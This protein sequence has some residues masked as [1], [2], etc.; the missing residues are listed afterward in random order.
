MR[1][2]RAVQTNQHSLNIGVAE[3]HA[4][5]DQPAALVDSD[6]DASTRVEIWELD[7]VVAVEELSVR[8]DGGTGFRV[9]SRHRR[10]KA[11]EAR[12]CWHGM[13]THGD[14]T[15]QVRRRQVGAE[16]ECPL[17]RYSV[18]LYA[19]RRSSDYVETC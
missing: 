17:P 10:A 12:F 13:E 19:P 16:A 4:V 9:V 5:I 18:A 1:L 3:R 6:E 11:G 15:R 2:E 7:H 8:P 14:T